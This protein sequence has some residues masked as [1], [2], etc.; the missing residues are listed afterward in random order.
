MSAA[1]GETAATGGGF[2]RWY[3]LIVLTAAQSGYVL[4]RTVLSVVMEPLRAEF[5]LSDS[6][7]GFAA[8]LAYGIAFAIAGIPMGLLV[9]R[10]NRS[11]LLAGMMTVWSGLTALCGLT[12]SYIAL[13]ACRMAVGVSESVGTPTGLSLL[14][15]YFG[16]KE[17]STAV[18]VWYMSTAFGV[19]ITF[20]VGG[21]VAQHFGWRRAFMLAGIPG[22]ILALL[23]VLTVREPKRGGIEAPEPPQAQATPETTPETAPSIRQV[24]AYVAARPVVVHLLIGMILCSLSLSATGAWLT[25]FLVRQHHLQLAQS[26]AVSAVGLGL[27]G[28]IGGLT[29][30]IVADR[31]GRRSGKSAQRSAMVAATTTGLSLFAGLAAVLATST[32]AAISFMFVYATFN[33]AYNGPANSLLLTSL[34]PR[35]RGLVIGFYQVSTNLVG[36]GLGPFL[37]G[38]LSDWFGGRSSLR[39]ALAT[40]L[41]INI[42]ST[43]HFVLAARAAGRDRA[44]TDG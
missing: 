26:G 30:G 11:R 39:W 22:L 25:S 24:A 34:Q 40:V 33:V 29:A 28:A 2:Y 1:P 12:Q 13:V 21:Y 5:R 8:G 7:L 44:M 23:I 20:L 35:M 15:D 36:F 17:R 6:Q 31:L 42:W 14:S 19:S 16:R 37:V 3:I 4:D 9:D 10:T 43:L 41:L 32:V 27:F 38:L 18:A